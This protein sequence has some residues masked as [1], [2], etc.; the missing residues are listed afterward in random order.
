METS[1]GLIKSK[2]VVKHCVALASSNKS[3][4]TK[5]DIGLFLLLLL[6]IKLLI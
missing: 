1:N 3:N 5:K 4:N 2:R 6:A